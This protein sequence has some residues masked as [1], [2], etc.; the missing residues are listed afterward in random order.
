MSEVKQGDSRIAVWM[1]CWVK[2]L[3]RATNSQNVEDYGGMV[4]AQQRARGIEETWF[5]KE[6]K[7]P[8]LRKILHKEQTGE[9][10]P[11]DGWIVRG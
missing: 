8:R 3:P 11:A 7:L 4:S 1:S 5:L 9:A 6:A 2:E 10:L